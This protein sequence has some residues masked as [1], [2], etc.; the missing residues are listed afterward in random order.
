MD[1]TKSSKPSRNKSANKDFTQGSISTYLV[2][3]AAPLIAG[4]ILQ[5]FYNTID[6]FVVGHFAGNAKKH[7]HK[8]LLSTLFLFLYFY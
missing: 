7:P 5:E 3:L 6:A 8:L 4:N 1:S 2:S